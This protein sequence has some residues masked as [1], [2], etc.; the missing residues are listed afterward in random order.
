[1]HVQT[2]ALLTSSIYVFVGWGE[3]IA[4][5]NLNQG[6]RKGSLHVYVYVYICVCACVS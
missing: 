5:M 3:N 6:C 4:V 2:G 1:M